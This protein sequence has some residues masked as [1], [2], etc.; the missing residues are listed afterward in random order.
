MSLQEYSQARCLLPLLLP[1]RRRWWIKKAVPRIISLAHGGV[2]GRK[3]AAGY[4]VS[5]VRET[6]CVERVVEL[7]EHNTAAVLCLFIVCRDVGR[8]SW[9]IGKEWQGLG[10]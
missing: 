7:N 3:G 2:L 4:R 6:R 9:T 1:C 8:P 10:S 5:K